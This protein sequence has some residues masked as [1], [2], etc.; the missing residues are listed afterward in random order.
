MTQSACLKYCES[1]KSYENAQLKLGKSSRLSSNFRKLYNIHTTHVRI[2]LRF[3]Q[4]AIT[5]VCNFPFCGKKQGVQNG[6]KNLIT[7]SNVAI[8]EL[9]MQLARQ[10]PIT[11][12]VFS[13]NRL[14]PIFNVF[15]EG[16]QV[17]VVDYQRN[18]KNVENDIRQNV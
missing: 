1:G 3:T 8:V 11:G 13:Y 5:Y 10:P 18:E 9:T 2:T 16:I 17:G 12:T 6:M 7:P 15:V 14:P 4:G